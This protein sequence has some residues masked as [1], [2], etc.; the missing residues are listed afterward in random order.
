MA[1]GGI[2]MIRLLFCVALLM[3]TTT[4]AQVVKP[5]SG[6]KIMI[7]GGEDHRVYLGCLSCSGFVADSVLNRYGDHGSK[8]ATNSIFNIYG[9]YGGKYADGSPC[10][11]YTDHAPVVVDDVGDY[12]GKLTINNNSEQTR[13]EALKSWIAG[14]C[15]AN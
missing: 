7:F 10:N 12:Y 14:V 15:Q 13:S 11:R 9:G 4:S 2:N 6:R 8:Y 3:A 1:D 5:P